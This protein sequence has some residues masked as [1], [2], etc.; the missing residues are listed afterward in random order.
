MSSGD[1][2]AAQRTA[3]QLVLPPAEPAL[4]AGARGRG[5][6]G[7]KPCCTLRVLWGVHRRRSWHAPGGACGCLAA[8]L[9]ASHQRHTATPAPARTYHRDCKPPAT[10]QRGNLLP[11]HNPTHSLPKWPHGQASTCTAGQRCCRCT[12]PELQA[13]HSVAHWPTAISF[14]HSA[15]VMGWGDLEPAAT[16]SAA[17]LPAAASAC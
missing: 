14:N 16:S 3:A 12:Q 15:S 5:E 11:T 8:L 1:S 2:G 13:A 10:P 4:A 7:G 9:S 17:C 6:G